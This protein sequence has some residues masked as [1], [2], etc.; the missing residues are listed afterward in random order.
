MKDTCQTQ[1]TIEGAKL[2][3]RNFKGEESQFN[4]KGA[5]NFCVELTPEMA[6][7]LID[8]GW[9]IKNRKA[10]EDDPDDVPASY[11]KVIVNFD[12]P[13]PPKIVMLTK[14]GKTALDEETV[15]TLDWAEIQKCD[16]VFS[17]YQYEVGGKTGIAAY[18][19]TMFVTVLEDDLEEKYA[20]WGVED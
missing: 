3:F 13:K 2:L 20:D 4:R 14:H 10:R 1:I 8:C 19:K 9:N 18:L 11:M 15:G 16:L 12:G 5:R 6:A 7:E 17:A